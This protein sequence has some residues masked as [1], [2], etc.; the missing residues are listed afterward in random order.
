MKVEVR[1]ASM[2]DIAVLAAGMRQADREEVLASSGHGPEESLAYSLQVSTV[3]WTGLISDEPVCMFGVAPISVLSG[4][5]AVWMLGTDGIERWPRTFLR[6]CH[7]CVETMLAVYPTLENYVADGNALS[8]AWLEWLG[9]TLADSVVLL[10]GVPF[11][12]FS[13]AI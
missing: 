5:G 4:R 2:D 10:G 7:P 11:R 12:H 1:P 8:K 13:R 3:A 9:F 6:R